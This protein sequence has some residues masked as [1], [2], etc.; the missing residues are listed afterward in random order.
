[1]SNPNLILLNPILALN[2]N[3]ETGIQIGAGTQWNWY[4]VELGYNDT[5]IE[6]YWDRLR[7]GHREIDPEGFESRT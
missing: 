7:L 5:R 2:P 4:S 6:W 1:M 3:S